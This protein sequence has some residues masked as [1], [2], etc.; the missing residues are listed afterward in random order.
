MKK[1]EQQ[2]NERDESVEEEERV[3]EMMER[4]KEI[5]ELCLDVPWESLIDCIVILMVGFGGREHV[6][7][8]WKEL[9]KV[10]KKKPSLPRRCGR[11]WHYNIRCRA[12]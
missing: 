9:K 12:D 1:F 2:K 5:G 8:D 3:T 4:K 11:R 10:L 6:S 7:K